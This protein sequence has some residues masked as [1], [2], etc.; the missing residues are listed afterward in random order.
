MT[1]EPEDIPQLTPHALALYNKMLDDLN[2][3]KRQQWATTNYAALLYAAMVWFGQHS[4]PRA[5][6]P[7]S[8]LAIITA[9]VA[10]GLLFKFQH[11]LGKLRERIAKVSKYCFAG[12][13]K[14]VFDIKDQDETV[15]PEAV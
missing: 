7:L 15:S 9:L 4:E 1:E 13:E 6:C 3:I 14:E 12:K 8:T 5:I 2:F 11:D 10:I